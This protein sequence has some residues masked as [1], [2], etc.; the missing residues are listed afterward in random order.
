[1][2]KKTRTSPQDAPKIIIA[3][4][5]QPEEILVSCEAGIITSSDIQRSINEYLAVSDPGTTL[6]PEQICSDETYYKWKD[7]IEQKWK[8]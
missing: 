7:V 3:E 2:A 5:M 6:N 8:Q 4:E 1:M